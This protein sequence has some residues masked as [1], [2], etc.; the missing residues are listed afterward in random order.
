LTT[1]SVTPGDI[2]DVDLFTDEALADPYP[3]YA[4]LRETGPA[5]YLGRYDVWAISRY[6]DVRNALSDWRTFSSGHGNV[7]RDDTNQELAGRLV[8]TTDPPI[9]DEMRQVLQAHLSLRPLKPAVPMIQ[10]R[11]DRLVEELAERGSFDG[12]ADLASEFTVSVVSDLVGF[13]EEGREHL[14]TYSNAL[15]NNNG[16]D[17]DRNRLTCQ[18]IPAFHEYC[19]RLLQP[20]AFASGSWGEAI[21]EGARAGRYPM[22][23]AA[24][25]VM[26]FVAAGM[27]T[28]VNGVS[29]ALWLLAEDPEQWAILRADTSHVPAAFNEALRCETP[30]QW[31]SRVATRSCEI[32]GVDIP[33][34]ARVLLLFGSANRDG[35]VFANPDTFVVKR[36]GPGH[37]GFGFGVHGCVGQALARAE[38][39][40]VLQALAHRVDRIEAS[41][42][43]RNLNNM[44][45]G[46]SS[47]ELTVTPASL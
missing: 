14:L 35:R 29:N 8:L 32:D 39:H 26:S 18:A 30:I 9:H 4:Q 2:T 46:L 23:W 11:A 13:P 37:L 28:T 15:F 33:A 40:A 7:L 41:A 17:N 34:G 25:S 1:E 27:D 20:G 24:S 45:R 16:P 5:V 6:H 21:V 42:V 43:R 3:I 22:E 19:G 47:L 10:S 12:V 36:D 44:L 31:F 38:G